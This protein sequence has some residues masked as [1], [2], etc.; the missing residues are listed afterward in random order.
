MSDLA[1]TKG[2]NEVVLGD[3]HKRNNALGFGEVGQL[4]GGNSML[5]CIV[6]NKVIANCDNGATI[7]YGGCSSCDIREVGKAF[8]DKKKSEA[9]K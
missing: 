2:E 3:K 7:R 6:C 4:K 9:K 5:L 8:E 1:T